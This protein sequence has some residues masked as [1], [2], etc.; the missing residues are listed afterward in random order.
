VE[1]TK[2]SS[3][4]E[5]PDA[6]LLRLIELRD[7]RAFEAVY[8]RHAGHVGGI[9]LRRLRDPEVAAEITQDIFT[10]LWNG[11][12]RFDSS[13]AKFTTWLFTIVRNRCIDTARKVQRSPYNEE[14]EDKYADSRASDPETAAYSEECR[15]HL[16]NALASLPDAQ[17]E[18]VQ[19]C[20]IEG[21]SH[22]EAAEH[23]GQPLGTIKSRVKIGLEKLKSKMSKIK[24]DR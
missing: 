15:G 6:E 4:S 23:L 11:S 1:P 21:Y 24:Q 10:Q 3:Y 2:P 22:S 12:S 20:I 5:L 9:C 18:A 19:L 14:F 7:Q 8:D 16:G 17:R 13:R